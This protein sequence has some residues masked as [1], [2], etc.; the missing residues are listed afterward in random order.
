MH[1]MATEKT[2]TIATRV[3]VELKEAVERDAAFFNESAGAYLRR[4]LEAKFFAPKDARKTGS[5]ATNTNT[6]PGTDQEV[7]NLK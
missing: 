5:D 4:L 1:A 6:R 2:V 7:V 3:P